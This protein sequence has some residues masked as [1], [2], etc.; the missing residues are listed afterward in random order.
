MGRQVSAATAA[1]T[2]VTTAGTGKAIR[3]IILLRKRVP[4]SRSRKVNVF[5]AFD[6]SG[7]YDYGP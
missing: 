5:F 3:G 7:D 1:T 6:A 4:G 2:T